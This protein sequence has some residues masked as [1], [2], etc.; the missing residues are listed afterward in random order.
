MGSSAL[1]DTSATSDAAAQG[2]GKELAETGAG[3]TMFLIIGAATMIAGGIGFRVLP[4][5]VEG[6]GGAAA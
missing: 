5:L 2:D 4:R 3:Q 1:T 6:R